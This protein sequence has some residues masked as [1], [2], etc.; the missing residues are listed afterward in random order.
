MTLQGSAQ[1]LREETHERLEKA[2]VTVF[3][4][5]IRHL[6][7]AAGIINAMLWRAQA[8]AIIAAR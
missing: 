3:A 4:A 6:A 7:Y 1:A 8:S 5:R 2:V